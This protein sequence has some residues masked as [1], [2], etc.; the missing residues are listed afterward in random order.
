MRWIVAGAVA[1]AV[2][3]WGWSLLIIGSRTP[4]SPDDLPE[5]EPTQSDREDS[6]D[7]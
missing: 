2:L 4:P 7:G 1:L 6:K 3:A 5:G